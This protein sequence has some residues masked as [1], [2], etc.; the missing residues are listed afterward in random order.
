MTLTRLAFFKLLA[1]VGMGQQVLQDCG[2][3]NPCLT[4]NGHI[5]AVPAWKCAAL[6]G[7][8]VECAPKEGEE[9]CP[10]GHPQ[11]PSYHLAPVPTDIHEYNRQ[12]QLLMEYGGGWIVPSVCSV[13]GIVY[14]PIA[15][16]VP[17]GG[18]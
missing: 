4:S 12:R 18:H 10:L 15:P 5:G 14:V 7:R 8:V 1:A 13:C 2:S 3:K 6:D 9:Y 16:A 17:K 11:K